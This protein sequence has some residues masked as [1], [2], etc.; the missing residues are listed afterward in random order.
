[1]SFKAFAVIF[2]PGNHETGNNK[3]IRGTTCIECEYV[4]FMLFYD[5]DHSGTSFYEQINCQEAI[6]HV[7]NG[8]EYREYCILHNHSWTPLSA[9]LDA[10]V[11]VPQH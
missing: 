11:S 6:L 4:H 8:T 10:A 1:M 9:K 5:S 7:S 3:D 2:S